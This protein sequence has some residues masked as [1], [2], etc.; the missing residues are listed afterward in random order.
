M[1]LFE[2]PQLSNSEIRQREQSLKR[3]MTFII[4][5]LM[6]LSLTMCDT[7]SYEEFTGSTPVPEQ[8]AET[9]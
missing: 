1:K 7:P 5:V 9:K 4:L 3:S 2:K 8:T 6:I